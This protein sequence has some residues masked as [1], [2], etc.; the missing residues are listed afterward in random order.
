[1]NIGDLFRDEM[2][3][4]SSPYGV[5]GASGAQF[6]TLRGH[7]GN[8]APMPAGA[9]GATGERVCKAAVSRQ[10]ARGNRLNLQPKTLGEDAF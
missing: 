1:M 4:L 2:G 7:G 8:G 6:R 5:G 10:F 3:R 9:Q